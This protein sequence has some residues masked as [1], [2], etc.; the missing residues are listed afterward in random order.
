MSEFK[1][2][3]G[4][5]VS[6]GFDIFS[7]DMDSHI[8]IV[9]SWLDEETEDSNANLIAAAPELLEA[10]QICAGY[11]GELDHSSAIYIAMMD[12]ANE[13]IDKALGQ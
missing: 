9:S 6:D 4:P 13:A 5:W 3:Q 10:L 2:T 1:G 7:E 11:L 12:K 8:C